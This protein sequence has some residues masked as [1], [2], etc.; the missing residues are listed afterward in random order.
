M[1]GLR[2]RRVFV[3]DSG[4]GADFHRAPEHVSSNVGTAVVVAEI[5]REHFFAPVRRC[6]ARLDR[7]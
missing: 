5:F 7:H 1:S 6:E 2:F 4:G 3:A